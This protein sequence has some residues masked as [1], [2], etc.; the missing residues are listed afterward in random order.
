MSQRY[1]GALNRGQRRAALAFSRATRHEWHPL[2][3]VPLHPA[4]VERMRAA[5]GELLEAFNN[6]VYSVQVFT[7]HRLRPGTLQL[8]VRR[9]DGQDGIPWDDLQRI[10]NEICGRNAVALEVY[11]RADQ[12]VNDANLRHLFVLPAGE[13]APF[14]IAGRWE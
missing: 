1:Q 3:H 12:F 6:N 11:P 9:H 13:D 4:D 10:K 14:T 2:E 5:T 8:V 7:R